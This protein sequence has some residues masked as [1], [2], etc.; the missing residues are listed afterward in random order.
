MVA[1]AATPAEL[2]ARDLRGQQSGRRA[3]E[4]SCGLTPAETENRPGERTQLVERA[5]D[6]QQCHERWRQH[7]YRN[8]LPPTR[9]EP[10]S[11]SS[12]VFEGHECVTTRDLIDY[13]PRGP[14]LD[15]PRW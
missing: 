9:K 7:P 4:V 3:G 2:L 13:R 5:G 15:S 11:R 8:T 1:Q 10:H 12:V 14:L 6:G